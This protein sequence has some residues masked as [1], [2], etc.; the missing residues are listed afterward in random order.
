MRVIIQTYNPNNKIYSII[1]DSDYK[2]YFNQEICERKS[3]NYPPFCKLIKII[4]KS[5]KRSFRY[6]FF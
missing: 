1:K 5:K 2:T 6:C 4:I 3:F